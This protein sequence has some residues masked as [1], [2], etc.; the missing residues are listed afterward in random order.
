[1]DAYRAALRDR[2]FE[3]VALRFGPTAALDRQLAPEL[4][5]RRLYRLIARVPVGPGQSDW[6]IWRRAG[7]PLGAE[8]AAGP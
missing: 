4:G 6:F 3:L 2:Y 1:V 7:P 5:E 8:R